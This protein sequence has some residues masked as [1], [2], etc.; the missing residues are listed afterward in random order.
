MEW[1]R[2]EPTKVTKVGWRTVVSKTFILPNGKSAV[3]DNVNP[4]DF[5]AAGIVALTKD[6]MV[7]TGRQFRPGPELLM[8]EIPGGI[9]DAGEDPEA[10][11]R[12]EM[13][14]ETGYKAGPLKFLGSF[15]RD[16]G[17]N[18]KWYYYLA[19]DCELVSDNPENGEHEFI[20]VILKTI[21]EFI[22]DAKK[23]ML[24]DPFAVLTAYDDLIEINEK[25]TKQ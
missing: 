15:Y 11:A 6:D 19:T 14:E 12:R 20:D 25:G 7:I 17:M 13:L 9:V 10:A 5:S 23:G 21:P 4:E 2:T 18:G 16:S 8:D 24:T 1:Q 3:F 22:A